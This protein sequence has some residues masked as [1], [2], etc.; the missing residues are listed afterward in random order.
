MGKCRKK[1]RGSS[2]EG[3]MSDEDWMDR[4]LGLQRECE[5]ERRVR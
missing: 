1:R 2:E 5:R 3:E 4:G